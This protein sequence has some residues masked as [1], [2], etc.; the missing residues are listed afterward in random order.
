[1]PVLNILNHNHFLPNF[2]KLF[3]NHKCRGINYVLLKKLHFQKHFDLA[4]DA[5]SNTI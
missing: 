3:C 2:M 4:S 1:M 5:L